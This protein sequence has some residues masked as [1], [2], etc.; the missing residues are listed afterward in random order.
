MAEIFEGC[1]M[2]VRYYC[3]EIIILR[4]NLSKKEAIEL[5]KQYADLDYEKLTIVKHDY[6]Y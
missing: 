3:D 4:H 1:F 6:F 5:C 2:I